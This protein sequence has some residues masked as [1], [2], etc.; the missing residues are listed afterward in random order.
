MVQKDQKLGA[1][2]RRSQASRMLVSVMQSKVLPGAGPGTSS[3]EP[4][5]N[6]KSN[7]KNKSRKHK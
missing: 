6:N 7:R 1:R 4:W 5:R 2:P 3:E